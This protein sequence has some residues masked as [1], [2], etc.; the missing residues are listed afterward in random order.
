MAGIWPKKQWLEEGTLQGNWPWSRGA[1]L[2][3]VR[4]WL[5]LIGS[6]CHNGFGLEEEEEMWFSSFY[7]RVSLL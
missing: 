4:V 3:C 2:I 6:S 1:V 7:P 5:W